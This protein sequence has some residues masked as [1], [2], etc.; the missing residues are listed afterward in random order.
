LPVSGEIDHKGPDPVYVQLAAILRARIGSGE[1]PHGRAL[2]SR[3]RLAA[4]FGVSR[5]TCEKALAILRE[6][7]LVKT[8][9][10]RGVYVTKRP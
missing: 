10:G 1:L 5:G 9:F 6:E 3:E 4:E 2:P 7:G 8:S